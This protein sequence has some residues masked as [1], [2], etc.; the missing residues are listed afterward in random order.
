MYWTFFDNF[1]LYFY[2]GN[3]DIV[4]IERLTIDEA[5][6]DKKSMKVYDLSGRQLTNQ[7]LKPGIYIIGG[8]KVVIK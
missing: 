5:D 1:R 2:G 3:R 6:N 4:G 8:K 7:H